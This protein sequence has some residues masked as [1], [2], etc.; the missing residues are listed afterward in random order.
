MFF[1]DIISRFE[2]RQVLEYW[3]MN[4]TEALAY[5][6]SYTD[7]EKTPAPHAVA[8][9]DLRR[10]LELL[11]R[12]DSPQK[13]IPTVH[14]TGTK[15]KGSVSAMIA[16]VLSAAGY[17]TGLYTSPHLITIRERFQV[18]GKPIT[19]SEFASLMAVVRPE[20]DAVNRRNAYGQLTTFEVLT[21]LCFTYFRERR[22]GFQVLEVGMGG[23]YDA[24]NVIEHP[25]VCVLTS[26]SLDHTE[27]LGHTLGAI[28][29]EKC[30]IIKTGCSVVISPQTDEAYRVIDKTCRDRRASLI[31]TDID[32]TW[33]SLGFDIHRQRMLVK[34]K[35][36]DYELALPLLGDVQLENTATSVAAL[37]VL[38]QRG[39]NVS[40]E[41]IVQGIA[42]VKWPG[43]FQLLQEKPY[44]LIDGAHNP[45]SAQRLRESIEKYFPRSG[46]KDDKNGPATVEKHTLV[47]GTSSDKD[48]AGIV[49]GLYP[50]FGRVIVTRSRHPRATS[51]ELLAAEFAK[52]GV[53]AESADNVAQALGLAMDNEGKNTLVCATGSLFVVGEVLEQRGGLKG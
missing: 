28:A 35:L 17:A 21:A 38:A 43:R 24:T 33:Q 36:G 15:G 37:E 14:I 9:Y 48:I 7:Y 30:G 22:V 2:Q 20:A 51:T 45:Y 5:I 12:L 25:E 27:I 50:A 23:T 3:I 42:R 13:T 49:D 8:K 44:L 6:E 41:S 52:H 18:N 16:S 11:D 53:T 19:K 31:R 10:V 39:F 46:A 1:Q 32:V 34:G 40:R 29:G 4:Y 47:I 26:I